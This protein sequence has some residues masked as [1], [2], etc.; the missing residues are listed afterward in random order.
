MVIFYSIE[1]Y[2][3][4]ACYILND[5]IVISAKL[6]IVIIGIVSGKYDS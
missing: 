5:D 2:L 3:L 1:N 4:Y 6:N